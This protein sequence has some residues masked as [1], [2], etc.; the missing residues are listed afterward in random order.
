MVHSEVYLNKYVVSIAPF[1]P[2]PPIQKTALFSRF[3]ISYPFSRG[4]ADPICVYVRTPMS[5]QY[6]HSLDLGL[7]DIN[8]IIIIYLHKKK[9]MHDTEVAF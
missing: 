9:N 8:N 2:P 4:S 3:L 1:S 6:F 5:R 7:E